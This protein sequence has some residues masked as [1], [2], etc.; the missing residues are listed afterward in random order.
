M[1][2]YHSNSDGVKVPITI[3]RDTITAEGTPPPLVEQ[4]ERRFFFCFFFVV[5]LNKSENVFFYFEDTP[6]LSIVLRPKAAS[7]N[8]KPGITVKIKYKTVS[9]LSFVPEQPVCV[10]VIGNRRRESLPPHASC[11]SSH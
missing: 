2:C 11:S 7:R 1:Q 3:G 10:D 6:A 4:K 5:C 9:K 8:E